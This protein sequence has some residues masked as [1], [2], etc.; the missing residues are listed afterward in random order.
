MYFETTNIQTK[1]WLASPVIAAD[2]DLCLQFW[3]AAK[4]TSASNLIVRR[5]F[6]NGTMGELWRVEISGGN[7]GGH[8]SANAQWTPA[9]VPLMSMESETRVFL[10]GNSDNGGFAVDDI[11]VRIKNIWCSFVITKVLILIF[12]I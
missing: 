6:S 11:L 12:G 7:V 8:S 5:Q 10:E 9:Q 2:T 1:T 4:S 3:F